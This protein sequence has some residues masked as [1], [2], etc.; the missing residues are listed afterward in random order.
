[1]RES[2]R[3]VGA[4]KIGCQ[5]FGLERQGALTFMS[6]QLSFDGTAAAEVI[7]M[8][9]AVEQRL[10]WQGTRAQAPGDTG[11]VASGEAH[12]VPT[13]CHFPHCPGDSKLIGG[14]GVGIIVG[15]VVT[16]LLFKSKSRGSS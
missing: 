3:V 12:R 14:V 11:E 13:G 5:G 15:A 1:M 16:A 9:Q 4:T 8:L 6:Y 2:M 7:R 10:N